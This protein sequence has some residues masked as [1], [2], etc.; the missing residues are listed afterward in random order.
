MIGASNRPGIGH[1]IVKNL[2]D[3]GYCGKVFAVN[4]KG[5]D[6]LGVPGY[7]DVREIPGDVDLGVLSVPSAGILDVAEACGQKG[8]PAL[9]CITAGFREIG[10][11]GAAREKELMRIVDKYNMRIV[12][13]N[14]MGVANTAPGVRLSAT[15]LSETPPVGSVAFLTQSGALGA[16]LIDFAGELDVG[17]SVVVSMGNMTFFRCWKPMKIPKSSACTW[18]PFRSPIA[19]SASCPG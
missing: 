5:E 2:L 16:S 8:V 15:I 6:V 18:R 4:R 7:T 10:P 11:E 12:G 17:F 19:L 1:A 13:P 14:C 3:M 9:V